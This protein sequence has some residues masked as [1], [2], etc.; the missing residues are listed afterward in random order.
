MRRIPAG[1]AFAIWLLASDAARAQTSAADLPR[2]DAAGSIGWLNAN[3]SELDSHNDWYNRGVHG[4][5]SFGWYWTP[6]LKTEIEGSSSSR[7]KFNG[8]RPIFVN[9]VTSGNVLGEY[10]FG[11]RR[12]TLGQH[13]Q[14]GE[15]AWFHPHVAAGLDF[16]W[17]TTSLEEYEYAFVFDPV[18]RTSRPVQRHITHGDRRDLHVRPFLAAGFKSYLTTR[19]FFRSDLRVVAGERIEDVLLRFGFGVDF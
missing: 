2:A 14:F 12:L 19:G 15:N 5:I 18:T 8:S 1:I 11:T 16:N 10:Q 6:H 4:A 9:G 13:Y 3:K 7:A 17:E